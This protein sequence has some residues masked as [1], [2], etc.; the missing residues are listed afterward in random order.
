MSRT[1]IV[2]GIALIAV[3]LLWPW[4]GKIG[5]GRLPDDVLIHG[6]HFT[7]YFPVVTGLVIS[8]VISLLFWLFGR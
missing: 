2:I 8:I 5:L 3:G 1:L 4:L 7:F 6:K